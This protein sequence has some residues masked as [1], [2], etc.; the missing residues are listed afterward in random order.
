MLKSRQGMLPVV[1]RDTKHLIGVITEW[2]ILRVFERRFIEDKHIQQH[3][4]I[5]SKALGLIKKPGRP[6]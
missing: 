5:R 3:I 1:A 4:S 6:L 2:D